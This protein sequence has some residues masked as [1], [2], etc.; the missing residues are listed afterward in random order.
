LNHFDLFLTGGTILTGNPRQPEIRDGS[1]GVRDG[2]IAWLGLGT[3]HGGHTTKRALKL[4]SCVVTPGFVNTHT[5]SILT[6]VRG[7]AIDAGFAPSYTPGMPKGPELNPDQARAFARLGALEALLFGSTVL[8]DHFVHADVATEAMAELGVRLCPSWRIHDADFAEVAHG[9]WIHR[10]A[11]GAKMLGA[12]MDLYDRWNGHPRVTVNL[13]AHAVDTCS[14]GLLREIAELAGR[15]S[16]VVS[17]HLAQSVV[18]LERVRERTG[19]TSTE[20][21]ELDGWALHLSDR[22]RHCPDGAQRCSRRT[23]P[24]M[25]RGFRPVCTDPE[26]KASRNQYS[27][28]YRYTA[29]RHGR[30]HALGAGDR[31]RANRGRGR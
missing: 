4:A 15:R 1:I 28:G 10:P 7:V 23:H 12:A 13:A 2:K 16:L 22:L 29:R 30:T 17:T 5:H 18:E 3:P 6:M 11:I 14:D 8:G 20:V 24:E 9:R 25:Q 21:L 19:K 26:V 27:A 31:A